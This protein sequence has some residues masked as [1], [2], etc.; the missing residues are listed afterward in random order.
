MTAY[1]FIDSTRTD[2]NSPYSE[3]LLTD[4][5]NNVR[6][7]AEDDPTLPSHILAAPPILLDRGEGEAGDLVYTSNDSIGDGYLNVSTFEVEAGVLLDFVGEQ[8]V[9]RATTEIIIAGTLRGLRPLSNP[10]TGVSAG[11]SE[12][13]MI[14]MGGS[15]GGGGGKDAAG[16]TGRSGAGTYQLTGGAGG[17]SSTNGSV[18]GSRPGV[19]SALPENIKL[20]LSAGSLSWYGGANGG[21]GQDEGAG[22]GLG[23]RGGS[24]V[25]LVA[26]TITIT[27]TLNMAGESGVTTGSGHGGGGGGGGGIIIAC[28]ENG[29]TAGGGTISVAGGVGG[30]ATTGGDG[31]SGG[32]GG[33]ID[34]VI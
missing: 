7:W 32:F 18:G 27:G 24:C 28:S 25:V 6:A 13:M 17:P 19:G 22:G 8:L 12:G 2:P 11:E 16:A 29:L 21:N 4:L 34:L 26:P 14:Q 9:I 3:D 5:D 10:T 15:G 30:T 23:G 31:G 33:I 20:V 1:V